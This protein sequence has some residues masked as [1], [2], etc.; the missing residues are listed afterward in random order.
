MSNT[1]LFRNKKV[2]SA[3]IA[4]ILLIICLLPVQTATAAAKHEGVDGRTISTSLTGDTSDW[5][6]IAR[7]G[8]YA[9][10]LRKNPITSKLTYFHNQHKNLADNKYVFSVLRKE[11]NNWYNKTLS[12]NARLRNFAVGNNINPAAMSYTGT[13]GAFNGA[14]S[15][16]NGTVSPKGDEIAFALSFGEAAQFCGTQYATTTGSVIACSRIAIANFNKLL[17]KGNGST[18][19]NPAYWLRS[20][21]FG[22]STIAAGCVAYTGGNPYENTKGRVYQHTVIGTYGHYR[23]AMW[24]GIGLFE[25]K[26][27][28]TYNPNG[29]TGSVNVVSISGNTNYTIQNQGY[30]RSGY[31]QNG[32]NSRADGLGIPYSNDQV[33]YIT[34][35]LTLYAQ[36]KPVPLAVTYD[37]NGG[38]GLINVVSVSPN[39][40]YTIQDQGYAKGGYVF[41]GWN[42]KADG[43]GVNY[44][45]GQLVYM[46]TSLTLY[47]KWKLDAPSTMFAIYDPNGGVGDVAIDEVATNTYY[48]IKDQGYYHNDPN[49]VF[50]GWN[51]RADGSGTS[52]SNNQVIQMSS[53][54]VLFA[55]WKQKPAS[56]VYVIYYQNGGEGKFNIAPVI[57]NTY[58]TI[59]DQGYT[60]DNFEFANWNTMHD[61]LGFTYDNGDRI[62]V[63]NTTFLYAQW[64]KKF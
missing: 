15:I 24:V 26:F 12:S 28:V 29:G 25:E 38:V 55:Q 33:V 56:I 62:F 14:L 47:A 44:T 20:E 53:S 48:T 64:K 42:T 9:L 54:I 11:L 17:P 13:V 1:S 58:Y 23:P 32:W 35:A 3:V 40:Y 43:S 45:N 8:D 39:S 34:A 21:G 51:S 41:D 2:F 59:E 6:E 19:P 50:D 7:Y 60:M 16:P 37:P 61:G 63:T 52:Y 36:W 10:I 5:I 27:S 49:Y 46:S 31:T 18:D 4:A 30:T 57:Q 22:S